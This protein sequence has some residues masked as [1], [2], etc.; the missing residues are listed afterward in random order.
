VKRLENFDLNKPRAIVEQ[1]DGIIVLLTDQDRVTYACVMDRQICH[2]AGYAFL[3]ELQGNWLERLGNSSGSFTPNSEKSEFGN[4]EIASMMRRYNSQA[5][6]KHN[7]IN[8]NIESTQ[9]EMT[10]NLTSAFARSD[11]FPSR[12]KEVQGAKQRQQMEMAD[13]RCDSLACRDRRDSL[14][15]M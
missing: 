2:A 5:F 7:Q 13:N 6:E 9:A 11:A 10:Q 12:R 15:C 1:A 14:D 8:A 4:T 3:N